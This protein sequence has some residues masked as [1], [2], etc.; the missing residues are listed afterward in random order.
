MSGEVDAR[1]ILPTIRVPTL[2]L[3]RTGD[4][5]VIIDAGRYIADH[6]PGATSP[7]GGVNLEQVF[8]ATGY[9]CTNAAAKSDITHYGFLTIATCGATS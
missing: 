8:G 4:A 1:D 6:I 7:V 3:H 2:V 5:R 9:D